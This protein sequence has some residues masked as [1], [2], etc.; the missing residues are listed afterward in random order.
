M[1]PLGLRSGSK[2]PLLPITVGLT[3]QAQGL[4]SRA[5]IRTNCRGGYLSRALLTA[6]VD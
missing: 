1:Q 4:P 5:P 6:E 3:A 2:R